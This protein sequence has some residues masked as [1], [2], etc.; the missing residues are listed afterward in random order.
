MKRFFRSRVRLISS[1][2][3]PLLFLFSLGF[4]FGPIFAKAGEGNYI[5]FVTPGI[6]AMSLVFTGIFS[7]IEIIMG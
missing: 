1:L 5:Q 6:V 7:G 2:A 4:G 3:M